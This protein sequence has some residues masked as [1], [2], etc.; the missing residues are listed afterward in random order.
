[1][2]A[3][4]ATPG[5][6]TVERITYDKYGMDASFEVNAGMM[7]VV[8]THVRETKAGADWLARDEANV[9]LIASAPDLYEALERCRARLLIAGTL[10]T[11]DEDALNLAFVALAKAG[12]GD[13]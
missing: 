10:G 4:Q 2:S 11:K 1:M 8:Q 12:G 5:P 9:N 13:A 3:L 6:W 7:T